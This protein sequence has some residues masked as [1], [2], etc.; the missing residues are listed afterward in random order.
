MGNKVA[1]TDYRYGKVLYLE[2]G[3]ENGRGVELECLAQGN[4][5]N[6]YY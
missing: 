3:A 6:A 4:I 1:G 2:E 5:V